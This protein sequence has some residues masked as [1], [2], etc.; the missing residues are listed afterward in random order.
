MTAKHPVKHIEELLD[1]SEIEFVELEQN[2]QTLEEITPFNIQQVKANEVWDKSKGNDIKVAVLD[3]GI[4]SHLDLNI[5]GG[6][7]V[8][9][10]DYNDNNGHGT[11]VAGVISALINDEGI[12]GTAPEIDLYAV[13][14]M[15]SSSGDL[16]DA[17]AGLE[18][19]I[20]NSMDI[21]S[22]SFGFNSYSQIFKEV[23]EE[24]YNNG[25]LLVAAAG[26]NGKDDILYPAKYNKVITKSIL[27][28]IG[29][30]FFLWFR[31]GISSSGS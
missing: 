22:M 29:F 18:W 6:H 14:I 31:H 26:N 21:V 28:F 24:A 30:F 2:I 27:D 4:A 3:T 25:I 17:I 12:I 13:K 19:A 7:S 9:S 20:N 8:I 16:S 1:D 10:N 23:L 5:A 15:E 11:A